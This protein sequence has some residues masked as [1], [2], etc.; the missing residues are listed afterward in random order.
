ML[1]L[2][3]A[4]QQSA[5]GSFSGQD[6]LWLEFG[7]SVKDVDNRIITQYLYIC[8]GQAP[9]IKK[10]IFALDKMECFYTFGEKDEMGNYIFTK[11]DIMAKNKGFFVKVSSEK[12]SWCMVLAK[13][14]KNDRG[15]E[16]VYF[17]KASFLLFPGSEPRKFSPPII[18]KRLNKFL[19]VKI[20]QRRIKEEFTY[21]ATQDAPLFVVCALDGKPFSGKEMTV[22]D[23]NGDSKPFKT[24]KRGIFYYAPPQ[25]AKGRFSNLDGRAM[26]RQHIILSEY[27]IGESAYRGTY[28]LL[29]EPRVWAVNKLGALHIFRKSDDN[30]KLGEGEHRLM[31]GL[32]IFMFSAILSFFAVFLLRRRFEL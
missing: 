23:G 3:F 24:N 2:M 28:A 15:G 5:Y 32:V 9:G 1:F 11:L 12:I 21:N 4:T 13:G 31:P 18:I 30:M 17:A 26:P 20:Y 22:V 7:D 6:Y 25:A 19:D 27:T 10:D 16:E 14:F 8:Y 29:F